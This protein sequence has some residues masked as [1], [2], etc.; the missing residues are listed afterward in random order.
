[1]LLTSPGYSSVQYVTN[2]LSKPEVKQFFAGFTNSKGSK[3]NEDLCYDWKPNN[4][5]YKIVKSLRENIK[6]WTKIYGKEKLF[7]LTLT[8]QGKLKAPKT[9]KEAQQ[10]FNN[11]NRQFSRLKNVQWLYKGV[12]PQERG[13]LHYHIIGYHENDLGAENLDWDSYK[14]AGE[15]R[16][17]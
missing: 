10:R 12:E 6:H 14:K 5:D 1:M 9:P 4:K 3:W 16:R 8:F 15:Y 11:F 17:L 13:V 2:L 7:F